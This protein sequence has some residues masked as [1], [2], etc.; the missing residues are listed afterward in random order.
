MRSPFF[1]VFIPAK[2]R[3]R[4][5]NDAI[6][7]VLRQEFQD[8]EVVISNNG[9]DSALKEVV[10]RYLGDNRVRYIE[11]PAVLPMHVHWEKVTR[12][13]LGEY[14]MVLTDRSLMKAGAIRYLYEQIIGAER[15]PDVISWPWDIYY[16][17]LNILLRYAIEDRKPREL[18]SKAQLLKIAH[19]SSEYPYWLPRGLNACVRNEFAGLMRNRHGQIFR[20]INP[21]YTFGYLCLQHTTKF[22]YIDCSL[23]V[24]Q[25]L[26]VSNGGVSYTGD[27][28]PYFNSL[29]LEDAFKYAPIKL[30]LV[31][32]GIHEDFLA[33]ATL[34]GRADL[35]QQWSR[36]NYYMECLDEINAKR[37]AG[38]LDAETLEKMER[39]VTSALSKE[40]QEVQKA[41]TKTRTQRKKLRT[42]VIRLIKRLLGQKMESVRRFVLLRKKGAIVCKSAL[43]AAGFGGA[44]NK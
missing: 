43:E 21:D 42:K 39:E 13:L 19:G 36:S 18:D 44:K 15:R 1:S 23:V 27:A 10:Q 20:T 41:V 12:D 2:G 34:C 29:M 25:G 5:L 16:D 14:V 6:E 9:A 17:H 11:Q 26:K 33:I 31:Q 28:S 3:P 7:S 38:I 24:S 32:N 22:T 30:P 4:Y 8:M 35:L 37:E 40:S